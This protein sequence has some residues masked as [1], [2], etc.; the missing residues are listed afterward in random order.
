[1]FKMTVVDLL[2]ALYFAFI[3]QCLALQ[4]LSALSATRQEKLSVLH[5]YASSW[6]CTDRNLCT[7]ILL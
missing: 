4:L 5:R 3:K 6:S 7:S 1:M 2:K